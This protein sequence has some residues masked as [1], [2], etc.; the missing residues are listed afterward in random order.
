VPDVTHP[1]QHWPRSG[2]R[3]A[4]LA[5]IAAAIAMFVVLS[6]L[7][8]PLRATDEGGTVA[9]ELAGSSERASEIKEAWRAEAVLDNGAFID[10]LDFLF[11]PLYAAALAGA[12]VAAAGAFRRRGNERLAAVGIAIAWLACAV[13]AFDWTEN[14]ALAVVLLD[15][16]ESPWPAIAL[17]AA[18]PKFA[19][20]WA[21]LLYA[22]AGGAL[23][24]ARR[25]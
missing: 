10:G 8:S 4:L 6:V 9:L 13:A 24:L 3:R 1:F 21:A 20:S 11:A 19:G 2:R 7:D 16:P 22:L 18:I 5:L 14:I 15:Q 17:A 12:C 23:A 25:P